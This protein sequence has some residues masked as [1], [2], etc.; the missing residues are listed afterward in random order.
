M[1]V[2][3]VAMALAD[4]ATVTA[5][6]GP[7]HPGVATTLLVDL[8]FFED[9]EDERPEVS[10]S[11][12]TLTP[13]NRRT[14]EGILALHWHPPLEPGEVLVSVGSETHRISVELPERGG[15]SVPGQVDG[16]VGRQVAIEFTGEDLPSPDDLAVDLAEGRLIKAEQ[17]DRGLRILIDP[18]PDEFAR[19]LPFALR[20]LR[21]D[22]QPHF[23]KI[24]LRARASVA[25]DT[26]PGT[27]ATFD[28][29]GR[30]YGPIEADADG[31][32]RA[33]VDQYPGESTVRVLLEDDLGNETTGA[34]PLRTRSESR[35]LTVVTGTLA[36][37]RTSPVVYVHALRPDGRTWDGGAPF[38][39]TPSAR[40]VRLTPVATGTWLTTPPLDH[41]LERLP[42][43]FVCS[44]PDGVESAARIQAD[45]DVPA[46]L[47]LR[48]WPQD[49]S[50]DRPLASISAALENSRGERLATNAIR[51]EAARGAVQSG[52]SGGFVLEAEYRGEDAV[53]D[54]RDEIRALW[55]P[56]TGL[57]RVA[58]LAIGWSEP[59]AEGTELFVR[60][61]DE[62]GLP[63]PAV[64]VELNVAGDTFL[65]R[66]DSKGWAKTLVRLT[67]AKTT[68]IEA[69]AQQ[70]TRRALR[71]AS[72]AAFG[73]PGTPLLDATAEVTINPGRIAAIRPTVDPLVLYSGPRATASVSFEVVDRSGQGIEDADVQITSSEGSLS[74][75]TA[76]PGGLYRVELRPDAGDRQRE[77]V[78]TASSE[79]AAATATLLIEPRPVDRAL[80]LAAGMQTNL[81]RI[82]SPAISL[83]ID[84]RLPFLNR[85]TLLRLGVAIYGASETVQASEP[86]VDD[87]VRVSLGL[88]PVTVAMLARRESGGRAIWLGLGGVFTGYSIS[89]SFGPESIGTGYGLLTPGP[90]VFGGVGQR[91]SGG[92]LMAEARFSSV[93]GPTGDIAF[94]KQVGGLGLWLG[95][96]LIY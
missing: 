51:L 45:E 2:L 89:A 46:R 88:A 82:T 19:Y 32:V 15:W 60:A 8:S 3:V 9:S 7:V 69:S 49:L 29:G 92:E 14:P 83:D 62:S 79:G 96:R 93:S 77:V 81:R 80:S 30:I 75:I 86:T 84:Q 70:V 37:G 48:V 67:E 72:A 31:I 68:T 18:G 5:M 24:R 36:P 21:A 17:S 1:I 63:R 76:E 94:S 12:G 55:E 59:E 91:F 64:P 61:T 22:E 95:Y 23:G 43:R 90:A 39:R 13:S 50:T 71:P 58:D 78:I 16:V 38:C 57:G 35:L 40:E 6:N 20:D 87:D 11:A 34:L 42:I 28:V 44:L 33:T 54:G 26:E 52:S 47:R 25:L 65:L 10:V 56:G 41:Q 74:D 85:S 66:T 27:T 53:V 73:A 4:E